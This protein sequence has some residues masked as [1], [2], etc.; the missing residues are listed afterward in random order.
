MN[1][2]L[3]YI[4][5]ISLKLADY[6]Y[7]KEISNKSYNV[8]RFEDIEMPVYEEITLSHGLP[9]LCILFAE[10]D[11]IYP[12][13]DWDKNAHY[14]LYKIQKHIE[15]GNVNNLSMYS[16]YA[17]IGLAVESLS[18]NGTR[19]SKFRTCINKYFNDN[20]DQ[21]LDELYNL[22]YCNMRDY[23]VISGVSGTLGYTITQDDLHEV[24]KKIGE[25]L[26]Y[27]CKDIM[28]KGEKIPGFYIPRE[29]QFLEQEK[30][31]YKDGNFNLGLS[32]GIPGIL[33]AL[34]SLKDKGYDIEDLDE[35]IEKIAN[36]LMKYICK[37]NNKWNST[38]S[39]GEYCLGKVL[40]EGTRDA[41]CYGSPGVSYALYISGCILNNDSYKEKAIQ[42]MKGV[43]NNLIGIASPT[44]C[45]GLSGV[46]YIFHRFYE[47][48]KD[49]LFKDYVDVL[50]EQLWKLYS[51]DNP[52]GFK[53]I[54]SIIST[55]TDQVGI[56]TG[57]AGILLPLLAVYG[58]KYT[59]WDNAFLLGK[60][61]I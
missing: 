36:F 51:L 39:F 22:K 13:E 44:F 56:L 27:R 9:A 17:G 25:Y 10:L 48:T 26:V 45:H 61:R 19:Y 24:N 5:D 11:Y 28:Y 42:V 20:I 52:Y 35:S 37:S 1:S 40:S 59:S 50:S 47:L 23:D 46:M 18:K 53:N 55:S 41:W 16:G 57:I 58:Y 7:I 3:G 14:Y 49:D 43:M 29:N 30:I 54:E 31:M 12:N 33:L 60:L 15:E 4:K 6:E 8:E 2:K 38:I 34:C 32:H 21:L